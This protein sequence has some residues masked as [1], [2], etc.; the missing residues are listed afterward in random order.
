MA[1]GIACIE[2]LREV[3]QQ[4]TST[5]VTSKTKS[6]DIGDAY[7]HR[8][9]ILIDNIGVAKSHMECSWVRN[10]TLSLYWSKAPGEDCLG[11]VDGLCGREG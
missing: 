8:N 6:K 4:Y 7:A 1:V 10:T 2:E 9:D 5:T 11:Q 3:Q